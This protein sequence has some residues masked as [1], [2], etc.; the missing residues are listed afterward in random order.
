MARVRVLTTVPGVPHVAEQSLQSLHGLTSQSA[1]PSQ[2]C[3]LQLAISSVAPQTPWRAL[4]AS[5]STGDWRVRVVLAS[6]LSRVRLEAAVM[7]RKRRFSPSQAP[8]QSDQLPL[9]ARAE[10][11]SQRS[12]SGSVARRQLLPR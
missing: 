10:S 5:A 7:S 12:A 6:G 11:G 3:W 9:R 4:A 2:V 8:L 1:V